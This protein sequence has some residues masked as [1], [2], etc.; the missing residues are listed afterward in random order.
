LAAAESTND[1]EFL[2]IMR[3]T[4]GLLPF[5]TGALQASGLPREASM[6]NTTTLAGP[7]SGSQQ[8]ERRVRRDIYCRGRTSSLAMTAP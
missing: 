1:H 7:D 6:W 5:V 2:R 8:P 3:S 4:L